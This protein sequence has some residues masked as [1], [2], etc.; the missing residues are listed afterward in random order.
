MQ[1]FITIYQKHIHSFLLIACVLLL[2]GVIVQAQ[3]PH[4]EW[5]R[6][7][8][9]R[10]YNELGYSVATDANGN[11]Y[12]T[13]QFITK[14]AFDKIKLSNMKG[15]LNNEDIF[16][17][18]LNT[19]GQ[20]Q[21]AKRITGTQT[22]YSRGI[23]VDASGNTFV[24][25][26][27][28]SSTLTHGS[29]TITNGGSID[30][31]IAK[32][33]ANGNALW[34]RGAGGAQGDSAYAV[35]TDNSGNAYVIGSFGSNTITFGATTLTNQSTNDAFGDKNTDIF[36]TKYDSSGN[37][38]WAT[39][40]G[41]SA[42]EEG[43]DIRIDASGNIF[44]C[45]T[46]G[47]SAFM[48]DTAHV[49]HSGGYHPNGNPYP[50]IF[51]A[52]LSPT[53][54]AFWAKSAGW[55]AADVPWGMGIDN[56]GNSYITGSFESDTVRFS[57]TKIPNQGYK[58]F[59][60][61]KYDMNGN[62]A[63]V[64][65]AAGLYS[66]EGVSIGVDGS[67][68]SYVTGY[69]DS[70]ALT[71]GATTFTNV[72]TPESKLFL[73]KYDTDG[74]VVWAKSDK[75]Q[76]G[77][78]RS[79]EVAINGTGT[80]YLTGSFT[81]MNMIFDNI[82]ILNSNQS[83][84]VTDGFLLKMYEAAITPS[85]MFRTLTQSDLEVAS[86]K[87]KT[88]TPTFG[89]A[90]D[91]AFIRGFPNVS[92]KKDPFYPG[93][94]LLG[95]ARN[96]SPKAYGWIR[97]TL[98]GKTVQDFMTQTGTARGF[99]VLGTKIF[100]KEL[101]NP[102][103]SKYNNKLAG[104]LAALRMNMA[105][106]SHHITQEGF[107]DLVFNHPSYPTHVF[108][109][110]SMYEIGK[111]V[112]TMLT[113]FKLF[114]TSTPTALYDSAANWLDSINTSFSGALG[115]V[116]QSPIRLSSVKPLSD[117]AFLQQPTAKTNMSFEENYSFF[118]PRQFE[119]MQ[120]YPNPFNPTTNFGFRIADFGLVTLKIYDM[121]GREVATLLDNAEMEEG[122]YQLSFDGSSLASGLYFY[123]LTSTSIED[124]TTLTEMKRMMLIK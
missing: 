71:F 122:E 81:S 44:I 37:V 53:L 28:R 96:D 51:L 108:N 67:G 32:F 31:F 13:G 34:L 88:S 102:K 80:L 114:Y 50:D 101:K 6:S 75:P 63:W 39:S 66:E 12:L 116:T 113:Y 97:F 76:T 107:R 117:V 16:V 119:L 77:I 62:F 109:G 35:A 19:H 121:L 87:T 72:S 24:T 70:D 30:M 61:A 41:D 54:D 103:D 68:N 9:E 23:A 55:M 106:S 120:N 17:A 27:Y 65:T 79:Y 95:I 48:I 21:W 64:K 5:G 105:L 52:K 82:A 123:K 15:D 110:K 124:G 47:N 42:S 89:N 90:R 8:G 83:F 115:F 33:D 98:K 18:K 112:D 111:Y 86:V 10:V 85:T 69:F 2:N 58:D 36:I 4:Y 43:R 59:Y 38:L 73:V 14:I 93:G 11:A 25:G 84:G 92:S 1:E 91:T 40:Y 100:V 26:N 99:D 45:G 46:F 49:T 7:A 104:G 74:N 3:V 20:A 22:E 94:L 60:L 118:A 78:E 29:F 57:T 56:A